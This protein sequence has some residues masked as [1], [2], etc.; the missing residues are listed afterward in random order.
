VRQHADLVVRWTVGDVSAEGFEALRLSAHGARRIFGQVTYV[1]CVNTVSLDRA[2]ALTGSVP[3]DIQWL[4]ATDSLSGLIA[5][6]TDS[7]R[8]EGVGW[9]FAPTRLAPGRPELHLDNDCILW[10]M[11]TAIR[12][13]LEDGD[14]RCLLAEDVATML[15]QFQA[16]CGPEPRNSGMRGIPAGFDL[17]AAFAEILRETGFTLRSE[18]DE[19]GLVTLACSR[20]APPHVV[21]VDEVAICGPFPPHRQGLGRCGAHF[22]GLNAKRLPWT[23][24]ARPGE[25][26]VREHW[27]RLRPALYSA[28]DLEAEPVS[29]DR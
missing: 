25:A 8:A 27:R 20:H 10:S 21:A 26:H 15:G 22:V 16:L 11:P 9:K 19:Q 3:A 29:A 18:L 1:V 12:Q 6:H 5:G 2:R 24:E 7:S 23:H 13:W 14:S 28:L 17:E 4:D